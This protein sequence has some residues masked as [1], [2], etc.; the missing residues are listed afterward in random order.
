M[1]KSQNGYP[2]ND[3][4][5][6]HSVPIP[7]GSITVRRGPAGDLLVWFTHQFHQC[8]EALVWPGNWG[9]A[10][11]PIRGSTQLSNHASGTAIDLN[12]PQHPLGTNPTANFTSEQIATIRLLLGRMRGAIRWG[13]DYTSRKDPMH[14]EVVVSE[15][16]CLSILREV[17]GTT[18]PA[19]SLVQGDLKLGSKGPAVAALQGLLNRMFPSY[20][21]LVIDGDFG[22]NTETVV[23][24]FQRRSGLTV[25]GIVGKTSKAKLGF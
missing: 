17:T 14:F 6:V 22:K 25:D 23:K 12:A 1:V 15:A 8:V 4:T 24:E 18:S 16:R 9:Y 13:G 10:E 19:D 3:R 21:K 7:G 11:R 5:H 20:S 2:G